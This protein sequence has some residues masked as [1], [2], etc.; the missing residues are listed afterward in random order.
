[1]RLVTSEPQT[2]ASSALNI[3]LFCQVSHLEPFT[4]C[5]NYQA[6]SNHGWNGTTCHRHPIKC[7]LIWGF[8][9]RAIIFLDHIPSSI[10]LSD[11]P[12]FSPILSFCECEERRYEW[13]VRVPILILTYRSGT[14][15]LQV[16]NNHQR[17]R[18]SKLCTKSWRNCIV[19]NHSHHERIY[20]G[21]VLTQKRRLRPQ[22]ARCDPVA[23]LS[24]LIERWGS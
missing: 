18:R 1:M 19:L 22:S 24:I 17:V 20:F 9:E 16:T 3:S 4:W 6:A 14:Y 12:Q 13:H 11:S 23:H 7:W 10:T 2:L 21:V 15:E 5:P 8:P